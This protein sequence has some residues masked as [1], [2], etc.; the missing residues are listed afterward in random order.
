MV[1]DGDPGELVGRTA[2]QALLTAQ[3]GKL[4][5][6]VG[7]PE[8]IPENRIRGGLVACGAVLT[9]VSLLVGA[10]LVLLG[11]LGLVIGFGDGAL[12]VVALAFGAVLVGTHWGWVHVAEG[13]A[14]ALERRHNR[15]VLDRRQQWLEAIE[16]YTRHEVTT[17]VGEDGAISIVRVA[18]R[19]VL[20]G[21]HRFTFQSVVTH[22]E[23]HTGEEPSAAIVERAELLRRQAALDTQRERRRF[24]AVADA[25]ESSRLASSEDQQAQAVHRATSE[26]LSERINS[27]LRDPPLAE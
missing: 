20:S 27:H 6:A 5:G 17:S 10:M 14:N 3:G 19:P 9:A 21:D 26:A 25:H 15:E 23:V 7:R 22:R 13:T 11:G 4:P 2:D 18:H 12:D 16:P 1:Q 8:R 24:E